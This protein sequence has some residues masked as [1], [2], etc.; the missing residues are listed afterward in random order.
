M[1]S[2]VQRDGGPLRVSFSNN[3]SIL[4][5]AVSLSLTDF[6]DPKQ[7]AAQ[8]SQE[9]ST[10]MTTPSVRYD[11]ESL[12]ASQLHHG[13][14]EGLRT[15]DAA[16]GSIEDV[17]RC[18]KVNFLALAQAQAQGPAHSCPYSAAGAF[19]KHSEDPSFGA[20]CMERL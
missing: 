10:A 2:V 15:C 9:L 12:H 5:V 14:S 7:W 6:A 20:N 18:D 4:C 8:R 11:T 3:Y 19:T 17:V 1:A 16:M 13:H